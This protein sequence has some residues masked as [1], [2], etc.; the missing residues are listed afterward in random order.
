[1]PENPHFEHAAD[2]KAARGLVDFEPIQPRQTAGCELQALQVF[3]MDHRHRRVAVSDRSLEAHYGA[4][5]F[6]QARRGV[7]EAKRLVCAVS[8]GGAPQEARILG[9][10]ARLYEL[11]PV[12]SP[13]DIDPRSPA[14]VVWCDGDMFYLIASDTVS[15][16]DLVPIAQSVYDGPARTK[17]R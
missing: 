17:R 11:G 12:P 5:V 1:M 6:S 9:W 3:V 15:V 2:W 7:K 13:D 10:E 4:F 16:D 14:V 8:Y